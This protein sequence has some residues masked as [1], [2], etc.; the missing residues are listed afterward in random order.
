M[1]LALVLLLSL[2]LPMMGY[3]SISSEAT[4]NVSEESY[5][6]LKRIYVHFGELKM[7]SSLFNVSGHFSSF[8]GKEY[9]CEGKEL[10][11]VGLDNTTQASRL[12]YF[13]IPVQTS[14]SSFQI[15]TKSNDE[16]GRTGLHEIKGAVFNYDTTNY[17]ECL[18]STGWHPV[19]LSLRD[20]A[21]YIVSSIKVKE[22]SR[23]SGYLA[24]GDLESSFFNN[25]LP[26]VEEDLD[27]IHWSD[28]ELGRISFAEKWELLKTNYIANYVPEQKPVWPY[29]LGAAL[30]AVSTYII[31]VAFRG[32]RRNEK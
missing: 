25:L 31:V 11:G 4:E 7:S 21:N 23:T 15:T 13:D 26:Y 17:V 14:M 27:N 10:F 16:W 8:D 2:G 18:D 9:L 12:W 32:L 30:L 28:P 24:F 29:V 5:S 20:F 3:Q 6:E 19:S 1:K 22:P